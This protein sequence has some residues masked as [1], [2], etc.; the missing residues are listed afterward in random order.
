MIK[1]KCE[2]C[3]KKFISETDD[4]GVPKTF[5]CEKCRKKSKNGH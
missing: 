4:K 2:C 1:V 3:G 5:R